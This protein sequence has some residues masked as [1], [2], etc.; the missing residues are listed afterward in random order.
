M[1]FMK[2]LVKLTLL[3]SALIILFS[4]NTD[5]DGSSQ[6]DEIKRVALQDDIRAQELITSKCIVCHSHKVPKDKLLAPPMA[7]IQNVYKNTTSSQKEFIERF[8]EFVSAPT[9]EKATMKKAVDKYGLMAD[10]GTKKD[11]LEKIAFYL[12][13]N[14]IEK[15]DWWG[16]AKQNKKDNSP[17]TI[18]INYAMSAKKA[19]A[20]QLKKAI[21]KGGPAYAVDFCNVKAMPITDSVS[22]HF[23]AVIKRLS[24]QPRNPLNKA[25]EEELKII[26]DY[27]KSLA[28]NKELTPAIIKGKDST[29]FYSPIQTNAICL[30]CHGEPNNQIDQT[31]LTKLN[32]LYP[33]DK[34]IGYGTN[35][36][37]GIWSIIFKN[38]EE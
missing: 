24:D 19:L 15:P 38:I 8:V 11:D 9:K 28:S 22:N 33:N 29:R 4:C 37:R 17:E 36:I 32:E 21:K 14:E 16:K 13:N 18:G 34:A 35:E 7:A 20:L 31:T 2:L 30:K 5:N 6:A 10:E 23:N 3:F 26:K 12:Y 25:N 1:T 27:K